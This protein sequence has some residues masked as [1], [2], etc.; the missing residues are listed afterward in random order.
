METWRD[1]IK[2]D[3]ELSV[4]QRYPEISA[5]K[6]TL[7]DMGAEYASM[8]GSG[9]SVFGL[10]RNRQPEAEE[11]FRDCFVSEMRLRSFL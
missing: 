7:Y 11:V 1:T 9:S 6:Q 2:N 3:F 5:I 4:F 8:S 10:F